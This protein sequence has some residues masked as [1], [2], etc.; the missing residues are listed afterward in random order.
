MIVV[1]RK[2][3]NLTKEQEE[4]QRVFIL[5]GRKQTESSDKLKNYDVRSGQSRPWAQSI[6]QTSFSLSFA[7]SPY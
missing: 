6:D 4:A 5:I 2:I 1:G 3:A 7:G